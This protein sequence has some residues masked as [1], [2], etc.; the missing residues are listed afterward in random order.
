MTVG[1]APRSGRDYD[2]YRA[3]MIAYGR[4]NPHVPTEQVRAHILDLRARAMSDLRISEL[5]GVAPSTVY[6][7]VHRNGPN[8]SR[9]VGEAILAVTHDPDPPVNAMVPG[10]GAIRRARALSA[11]GWSSTQIAVAA[12]LTRSVVRHLLRGRPRMVLGSTAVGVVRAYQVLGS[13]PAPESR[14]S[15]QVRGEAAVKGWSV[16]AGWDDHWLD[17]SPTE[18]EAEL[19]R[20]VAR[21]DEADLRRSWEAEREGELSP[22]VVAAAGEWRRVKAQELRER[23]ERTALVKEAA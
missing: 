2:K 18:L 17:L 19:G 12:G 13:G 3:R 11:L 4:W 22:L 20:E 16:P 15:D 7:I 23:R 1:Q 9:R 6:M 21:M 10:W 8:T 5:A 14:T